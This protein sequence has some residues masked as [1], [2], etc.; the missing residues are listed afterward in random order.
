MQGIQTPREPSAKR[1]RWR[2]VLHGLLIALTVLLLLTDAALYRGIVN[3]TYRVTSAKLTNAEP[4]RIALITDVHSYA[5]GDDQKPLINRVAKMKPDIICLVGD[6]ADDVRPFEGTALLME[7]IKDIAPCFYVTGSHEYW[8][9]SAAIKAA[10]RGYGVTI[11]EG[12][13]QQITIKG[14]TLNLC[15]VDDPTFTPNMGY[16]M[17][18]RP[19]EQL[20]A[21]TFN[22]LL[23]H[24][25]DPIETFSQYGFD[26]VLSGHT[27]GGQV[28]IPFFLNGL[29]A[30]DQGWQPK[31]AGG[32]YL[33]NGTALVVSRGLSYYPELPRVF[34][35][36]EMVLVELS[37]VQ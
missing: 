18:L 11:L 23:S 16:D 22:I 8:S 10:M 36:P 15:G 7:G 17:L 3:R 12:K 6:I 21:D 37:Q 32:L 14:Q 20:P 27:H 2:R 1:N 35:P 30:P 25:P 31:Y 13:S 24:R 29:Y 5:H 4:I 26:L 19:F 28:R 34:N 33:V 9:D